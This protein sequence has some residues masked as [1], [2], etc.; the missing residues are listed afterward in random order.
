MLT[1]KLSPAFRNCYGLGVKLLLKR[2]AEGTAPCETD[3]GDFQR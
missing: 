2:T 1:T 3:P